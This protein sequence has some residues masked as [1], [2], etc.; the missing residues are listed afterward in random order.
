MSAAGRGPAPLYADTLRLCHWL[1]ERLGDD[2]G[3]LPRALCGNALALLEAV[4]LALK[5]RRRDEQLELADE[6]LIALRTQLRLA[7]ELGHLDDRQEVHA[8]E[9]ADTIGRQLGGWLRSLGPV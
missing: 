7:A 5:G 9:Q 8:L 1:L 4:A 6:R 3:P 2:P